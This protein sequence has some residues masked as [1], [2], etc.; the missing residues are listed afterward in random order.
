[1][2]RGRF[3]VIAMFL[4]FLGIGRGLVLTSRVEAQPHSVNIPFH[5]TSVSMQPVDVQRDLTAAHEQDVD[6][7]KV[8]LFGNEIDDAVGDY[9]VDVK[10]EIYER[11]SPDTEVSRLRPPV[12]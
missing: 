10:G 9:R 8:D 4:A 7:P 3:V 5:T 2:T 1:M 11:H 12:S 6:Q